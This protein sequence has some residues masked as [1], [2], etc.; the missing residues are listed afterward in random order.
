MSERYIPV[1]GDIVQR[2]AL[3]L[4]KAKALALALEDG[5]IDSAQLIELR[6]DGVNETV[7]F[8]VFAERPQVCSYPIE[9]IERL[10]A[11]FFKMDE[12]QPEVLALRRDFPVVPHLNL[13][14]KGA[15]KSLCLY[16]ESYRDLKRRWTPFR[17]VG[18]IR[19][20]LADTAEGTL[21]GEDQPL[22]PILLES[23]ALLLMPSHISVDDSKNAL[24]IIPLTPSQKEESGRS[25]QFHYTCEPRT[26]G[27]V[28]Q[29]PQTL[30]DLYALIGKSFL[31]KIREYLLERE[32]KD[33]DFL[34]SNIIF[35]VDFPKCR[36]AGGSIESVETWAFQTRVAKDNG[37]TESAEVREVGESIGI[38]TKMDQ[39]VALLLPPDDKLDGATILLD[40]LNPIPR[41][42]AETLARLNRRS[43][44]DDP[45]V[46]A[47]GVG[48]LGSQVVLNLA[49]AGFGKW[50]LVDHDLFLPHN[51]AR[52]ALPGDPF[53]GQKK[54]SAVASFANLLTDG[55][56]LFKA[57][58]ANIFQPGD[59]AE[60]LSIAL[61]GAD[62]ILDM[63]AS[64]SV[65][66]H[67]ALK[68]LGGAR[69]A[70]LFIS[71]Q[72]NDLVLLAED[73]KRN[74][75]LDQ[76]E[77]QYYR[78]CVRCDS[79]AGHLESHTSVMRYGQSCRDLSVLLPQYF[80]A[81]HSAIGSK[82]FEKMIS[83]EQSQITIWR[84]ND[85]GEVNKIDVP[86][87]PA[88][89]VTISGWTVVM[90]DEMLATLFRLRRVKLPNE[91]GGV[92][93]GT[94][95]L[96]SRT[97]YITDTVQSPPDS[98][99][100]P[101]LYIRGKAGL[102]SKVEDI[103]RKTDGMIEYIGEWHSHPVGVP[104]HPSDPD[105]IVFR[106]ITEVM[107]SEGLPA[108]M[109]IIGDDGAA[110]CFVSEM[111]PFSIGFEQGNV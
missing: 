75:Q 108:V 77:M 60:E 71:P 1:E 94:F 14:S 42:D 45:T 26:H 39:T 109:M 64:V 17:F 4:E 73:V 21:H 89:R 68:E 6:T 16:H 74:I 107:G 56:N 81:L 54:V 43:N 19:E 31:D 57:I 22:E 7:I 92:L 55:E 34:D 27:V 96:E 38:W 70:S 79:L 91:T 95:D 48:A 29:K 93:L 65:A 41:M 67:L 58:P 80:V 33:K 90:D 53:I 104:P 8:E 36:T 18:R 37:E 98:E 99:E 44:K 76:L 86:V 11:T 110:N 87:S 24:K 100:W 49:R 78:A 2:S 5:I 97:I 20:W 105:R 35:I 69:R 52:H 61:E 47:I 25:I 15:P 85:S 72:G 83:N 59:N 3:V 62:I 51:V 46:C 32:N 40:V 13:T 82:A 28:N 84:A 9:R 30:A 23:D 63:S 111:V 88:G 106:W 10:S 102:K 101:T 50:S 103:S 66:R 12:R